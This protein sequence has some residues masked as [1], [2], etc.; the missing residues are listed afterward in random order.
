MKKFFS[1]ILIFISIHASSQYYTA[2][3]DPAS[4]KWKQIK[5][6]V[7]RLVF[8]ESLQ[9]HALQMAAYM[10]SMAPYISSSLNYTPKR[11]DILLHNQTP[12]ANGFV[13]WAPRRSE[14]FT[15]PAQ[16]NVSTDWLEHLAIHEYRHVVQISK[17]NGGFTKHA[18]YLI[19]QHAVG[20]VVGI[21]LPLW[22][23]EGDA[24]VTETTLTKSG[25]GRSFD[26]NSE[27]KAQLLEKGI[28]S[29]DKA[30][31]G[32][33]RDQ[34]PNY[35]KMGYML[36]ALA[37]QEYGTELWENA[38][39]NTGRN[40]PLINPFNRSIK[41]QTGLKK[42]ELYNH[43]FK[44]LKQDWKKENDTLKFSSYRPLLSNQEEFLNYKHLTAID[45]STI[46]AE[47]IGPGIRSQIVSI[48]HFT[49]KI[50]PLI[51]IGYHAD[52]PLSANEKLIVWTEQQ[53][54]PRW[55]HK[56]VSVIKSYNRTTKKVETLTKREQYFS[57]SLHP[58]EDLLVAVEVTT[59]YKNYLTILNSET[60]KSIHKISTPNNYYPITP[61]WN[62][63]GE[64]I[65][66]V[67]LTEKGKA[68]YN[69]YPEIQ[70]WKEVTKP[71]YR[72]IR[73]P[74][75]NG[76]KFWYVA[77]GEISDELFL[78]DLDLDTTHQLTS[79]EYGAN[80]P[81]VLPNGKMIYSNLSSNGWRPV[82]LENEATAS[83]EKKRPSL[84]DQLAIEL[85]QQEL[86]LQKNQIAKTD[87]FNYS[88]KKYRK[89]N[90]FNVHSWAPAFVD[91]DNNNIHTGLSVMS[92]NLLS[93]MVVSAGY[94]ADPAKKSE[95]YNLNF[96]YRGWFPIIDV[97]ARMGDDRFV[98]DGVYQ[99][100]KGYFSAQ[101]NQRIDYFRLKAGLRVPLNL[102]GN[103]FNR[104]LQFSSKYTFESRTGVT[105]P[106]KE[107]QFINDTLISTNRIIEQT[108][109]KINFQGLEYSVYFH[110]LRRGS[111]RDVGTRMGQVVNLVYRHTPLGT[112][113]NGSIAGIT[114]KLYFPGIGRYHSI[115]LNNE[116]QH[117]VNGK[118]NYID[119]K[120]NR[121]YRNSQLLSYPR[122]YSSLY[123]DDLYIFR[124]N[125]HLPLWNP[126]VA[127]GGLI[128]LKRLR[129]MLFYDQA[130]GS[131]TL[132]RSDG[133][134]KEKYEISPYSTGMEVH[135]DTHF[136]RFIMPFS[137][138]YRVGLR[139]IDQK[140]F[141]ELVISNSLSGFLVSSI[142]Q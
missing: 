115:S 27:L 96:S 79:S 28:Y 57:P 60:G 31:M 50:T 48:D 58:K 62:K 22:W 61:S 108:L 56:A 102:S 8:E 129:L 6:P 59:D 32:S 71:S 3:T 69:Y 74:T 64:N 54:H 89:W 105:F 136:F 24:V 53:N 88:V 95:K 15:I 51:Y 112:Y 107:Y 20:A 101:T 9:E 25:R 41:K 91:F 47:L 114:T 10:D 83:K 134:P 130:I 19:G 90:L 35:Y 119:N 104:T 4:L 111:L 29:Y 93:T 12:T 2:G 99:N 65:V 82:H 92:Q 142:K 124:G 100:N 132:T 137:V 131:Y 76:N 40:S 11:I 141:H 118:F 33:Y 16:N 81:T 85:T 98:M 77:K 97:I 23:L 52:E 133:Q 126:D 63:N 139:S 121:H 128:Y 117:T 17:L 127:L 122:G 34:V 39:T 14:F 26:F 125:Y 43:L 44:Q 38:V 13:T 73:L 94:N 78:L 45:D 140:L 116:F 36:T 72:E 70:K 67:L 113:S 55:E 138:G 37:R 87:T 84:V 80:Y 1:F 106:S 46:I 21:Y 5:T 109:E 18:G 103:N 49:G 7:V 66:C 75:Q 30:Y 110:N 68:I 135:A 86:S 42:K 120:I 123:S